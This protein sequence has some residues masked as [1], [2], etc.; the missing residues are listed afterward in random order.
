MFGFLSAKLPIFSG[1]FGQ[2]VFGGFGTLFVDVLRIGN[3]M[4]VADF[5]KMRANMV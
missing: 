5:R 3:S 4:C 1:Q 2:S